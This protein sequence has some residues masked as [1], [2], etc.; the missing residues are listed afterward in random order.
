MR[1]GWG[2]C[3]SGQDSLFGILNGVDYDEWNPMRDPFLTHPY[4]AEQIQGKTANKLELQKEFGLPV[5][6]EIPLFG[7]I[8]RLAEQKGV[9]KL[10]RALEEMAGAN[11]Q[12]VLLGAARPNSSK[13][14][15]IWR[16]DFH[17]KLRFE[18][19]LTRA[20]RTASRRGPTS[21]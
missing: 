13:L 8:G 21:S 2:C 6:A 12:F 17:R 1:P 7:N 18:L 19:V 11:L 5:A 14:T 20:S 9:D 16:A 4:S 15:R 3:A 10:L